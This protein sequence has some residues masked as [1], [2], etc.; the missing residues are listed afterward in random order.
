MCM[1]ACVCVR[2]LENQV[3]ATR[4]RSDECCRVGERVEKAKIA[5]LVEGRHT[6]DELSSL[7][8]AEGN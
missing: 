6:G 3:D 1:F 5:N 2:I 8:A 7:G 4:E